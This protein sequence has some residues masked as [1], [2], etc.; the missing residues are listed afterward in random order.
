MLP[1]A[2]AVSVNLPGA[3][4]VPVPAVVV[5]GQPTLPTAPPSFFQPGQN[6]SII[7]V[8]RDPKAT[9]AGRTWLLP[10]VQAWS[11]NGQQVISA[12]KTPNDLKPGAA[13]ISYTG[14]DGQTHQVQATVFKIV[15]AFLDRS[16]LHSD[17]GATFEYDVLFDSQGGDKLCVQMHVAGPIVLVKAPPTVIPIDAGGIGKFGGKIRAVQVAPG[18]TVPFDLSPDIHVCKNNQ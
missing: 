15:R 6:V 13:Q 7:G 1:S 17:Q 5:Q 8:L 14:G 11:P 10:A 3:P 2:P 16:Q 12:F 18:S 4:A 9:Q